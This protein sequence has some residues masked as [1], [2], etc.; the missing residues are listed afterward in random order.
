MG[1]KAREPNFKEVDRDHLWET[2]LNVRIRKRKT[3]D[4]FHVMEI[5]NSERPAS[6]VNFYL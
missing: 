5:V 3:S 4:V 6:K 2:D 1:L